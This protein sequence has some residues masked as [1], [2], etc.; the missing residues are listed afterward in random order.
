MSGS[1]VHERRRL[2]EEEEI[3]LCIFNVFETSPSF[4]LLSH[5][6]RIL[7][8]KGERGLDLERCMSKLG[9]LG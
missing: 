2:E 6:R 1:G 9:A 8:E 7:N 3:P 5:M 4:F